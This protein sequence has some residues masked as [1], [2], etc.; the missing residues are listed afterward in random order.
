MSNMQSHTVD[1]KDEEI[2]PELGALALAPRS[3]GPGAA[4]I[5]AA[6]IGVFALGLLTT[7]AVISASLKGF[8]EDFQGS[9]GV[10]SLAGK[11]TLTVAAWL[12]AWAGLAFAWKG[13]NPNVRRVFLVALVLIILGIIGTFPPFFEAFE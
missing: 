6:G 4:A 5:L 8:L 11:T 7:L 13:K 1:R 10:G 9:V 2:A 3:D 12:V